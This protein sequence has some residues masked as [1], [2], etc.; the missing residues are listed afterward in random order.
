MNILF[1]TPKLSSANLASS[2]Q[3]SFISADENS[4][5]LAITFLGCV[6]FK[7][8][9][10]PCTL[11]GTKS[12]QNFQISC[13]GYQELFGLLS[14]EI[15]QMFCRKFH[16]AFMKICEQNCITII[17]YYYESNSFILNNSLGIVELAYNRAIAWGMGSV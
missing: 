14:Y 17:R 1:I 6:T 8:A 2:H 12:M 15:F 9:S 13:L 3:N 11:S 4:Q 10:L 16:Y 7:V 5:T